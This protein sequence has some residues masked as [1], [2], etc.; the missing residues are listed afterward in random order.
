[1]TTG[2]NLPE[3]DEPIKGGAGGIQ[4]VEARIVKLRAKKLSGEIDQT[5][6]LNEMRKLR[7]WKRA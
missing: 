2:G 1:M 7:G 3:P 6:L 4:D 5:T